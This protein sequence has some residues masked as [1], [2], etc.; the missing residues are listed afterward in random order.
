MNSTE[1]QAAPE[2]APVPEAKPMTQQRAAA[3]AK[4]DIAIDDDEE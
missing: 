3:K 4:L 2:E 1:E